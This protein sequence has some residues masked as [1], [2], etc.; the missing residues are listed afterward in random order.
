MLKKITA[1]ATVALGLTASAAAFAQTSP[2]NPTVD[3]NTT[4]TTP[5]QRPERRPRPMKPDALV[6]RT[7]HGDLI[8]G[9]KDGTF[10][11]VTVDRGK[12]VSVD[13]DK[14]TIERADGPKVTVTLTDDTRYVGVDSK[15]GL[16][17]GQPT[18]V[19]SKDG[20]AVGVG[21]REP[22]AQRRHRPGRPGAPADA[23]TSTTGA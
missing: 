16:K 23:G 7:V 14:L 2:A 8:V 5:G 13:G 17:E 1:I 12:L 3:N 4:T 6:G 20:K 11:K 21:Q 18:L 22:G 9:T 15:D 10:Q 19:V